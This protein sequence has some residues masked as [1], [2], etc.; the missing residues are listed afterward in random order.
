MEQLLVHGYHAVREKRG[1][2]PYVILTSQRE[3]SLCAC[4]KLSA[5]VTLNF[6]TYVEP[7]ENTSYAHGMLTFTLSLPTCSCLSNLHCEEY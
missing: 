7:Q 1:D 6:L 3:V 5:L 2:V 4:L